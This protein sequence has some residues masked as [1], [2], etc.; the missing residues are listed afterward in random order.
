MNRSQ[1]AF[2]GLF[3]SGAGMAGP[4]TIGKIPAKCPAT[5]DLEP[6][7]A[8]PTL[9]LSPEQAVAAAEKAGH[10]KCNSKTLQVLATDAEN[11]YV[12][13]FGARNVVVIDGSTGAVSIR[14]PQ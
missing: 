13:R 14:E 10:V 5:V 3:V 6:G 7:I 4:V 8:A 1:L 9:A 12:H 2:I 11:Y